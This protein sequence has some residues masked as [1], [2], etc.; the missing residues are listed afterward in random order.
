MGQ[1]TDSGMV[2][3]PSV[4]P[5][6]C[7][8]SKNRTVFRPPDRR[9]STCV[10]SLSPAACAPPWGPAVAAVAMGEDQAKPRA[11]MHAGSVNK[12]FIQAYLIF[13]TNPLQYYLKRL[14]RVD[15]LGLIS[16]AEAGCS[17]IGDD[18]TLIIPGR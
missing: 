4:R 9:P 7:Q 14:E 16:S 11:A 18:A 1:S 2:G 10:P 13:Q 8:A 3:R 12:T 5:C 6:D 17:C 15:L